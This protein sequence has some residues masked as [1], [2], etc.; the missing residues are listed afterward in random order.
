[1]SIH[2]L[3]EFRD[4]PWGGGN[5]FLKALR[6]WFRK[7]GIYAESPEEAN[8][9]LFNSHHFGHANEYLDAL[10]RLRRL[11][12]DI[13]LVQ[14]IDGPIQAVRGTDRQ[15]DNLI[16][17][18]NALL[19]DGTIFQ[20]EW[21]R[22]ENIRRGL[23]T[24]HHAEIVIN[25][26][27]DSDIFHPSKAPSDGSKTKLIATSWAANARKGFGY[28]NFLDRHLDWNRFEMKFVGN[29]PQPFK[30]IVHI[31]PQDSTALSK[32][33]RDSDIFV[34]GSSNDPCSNSLLE[35]LHSGLPAVALKSG[36]H[37]ELV[38]A[39][40]VLFEGETD[41]I[42]AI[43]TVAAQ[44]VEHRNRISVRSLCDIAGDYAHFIHNCPRDVRPRRKNTG[45]SIAETELKLRIKWASLG[46]RVSN[47]LRR[48]RQTSKVA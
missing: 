38:G 25:N 24:R 15:V 4:G 21:S 5:Q 2:I 40:G 8:A 33:L 32:L 26:A 7:K 46:S 35:A 3:Y 17:R 12:P 1:M 23:S 39:G 34:T 36:G 47:R 41:L 13:V 30:N 14:R 48:F 31:P 9:I 19:A 6:T 22:A 10:L 44:R 18:A 45:L 28:Y 43:E 27:P 37:P 42:D 20:T 16:Y 29:T 11:N